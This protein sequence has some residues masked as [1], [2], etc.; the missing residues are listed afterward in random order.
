MVVLGM[1]VSIT[2][3]LEFLVMVRVGIEFRPD[4]DHE[5]TVH[6]VYVIEHLLGV[7]ITCLVEF[8]ASPLVVFPVLPVL[9]D[10][11]DRDVATAQLSQRFHQ[12]LLRG[13]ALAALPETQHPLGHDGG[14]AGQRAVAVDHVVVAGARDE[15]EVRLRFEFTPEAD[16]RFLVGI[17]QRGHA[18][19]DVRHAAIRLPL[20]ADRGLHALLQVYGELVAVRVPGRPPAARHDFLRA[21]DRP[22]EACIILDEMVICRLGSLQETLVNHFRSVEV[23]VRQVLH[24]EFVLVVETVLALH[25]LLT[26]HGEIGAGQRAFHTLLVIELEHLA[27][28]FVRGGIA[29]AAPGIGVEQQAVA[30]RRH[31][32]RDAH[33]GVVLVELLAAAAVVEFAGLVLAESVEGILVRRRKGRLHRPG[34][35]ALHLDGRKD[36][37]AF[38]Q[39]R[40]TVGLEEIQRT[41]S[42]VDLHD[43]AVGSQ[44]HLAARLRHFEIAA[45]GL[46]HHGQAL[47]VGECAFRYGRHPDNLR[48]D[49]LQPDGPLP[50]GN[51]D[52]VAL[53]LVCL[54]ARSR[55]EQ[56]RQQEKK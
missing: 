19:A 56:C 27:Q 3:L 22:L 13:I 35:L 12:L 49:D 41:G 45:A 21:H 34:L 31:D 20:D 16:A 17:L 55:Q 54:L 2:G 8:V 5:A 11:V 37:T 40:R 18:Q 7:G 24:G 28:L 29:P 38:L 23:N 47:P 36:E 44:A 39:Q 14:L 51:Q 9:D 53:D 1:R 50:A 46:R 26:L 25:E 30:A 48:R 52:L 43:E 6:R 15:I 4:A 42:L 32:E 33:L 10:V